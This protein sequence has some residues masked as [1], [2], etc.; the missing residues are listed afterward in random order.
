MNYLI[1]RGNTYEDVF[2]FVNLFYA[3]ETN[4]IMFNKDGTPAHSITVTSG[5]SQGCTSGPP[6][7]AWGQRTILRKYKGVTLSIADDVH[8]I[9]QP[10]LNRR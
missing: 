1:S 7:L 10:L 5:T 2:P 9:L 4:V 6:Y 8:I 3:T